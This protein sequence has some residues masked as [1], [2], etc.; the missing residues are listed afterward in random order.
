MAED[1]GR[2]GVLFYY[3]L[4]NCGYQLG[5]SRQVLPLCLKSSVGASTEEIFEDQSIILVSE[6]TYWKSKWDHC[7]AN[8]FIFILNAFRW[9]IN[10]D[11]KKQTQTMVYV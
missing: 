9:M 3:L 1:G 8:M 4:I 2:G 7:N 6:K 10:H 5:E 11:L